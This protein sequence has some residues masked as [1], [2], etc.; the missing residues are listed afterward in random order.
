M[1]TDRRAHI[2]AEVGRGEEVAVAE[3]LK[4]EAV[5]FA[6]VL[7]DPPATTASSPASASMSCSRRRAR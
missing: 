5:A 3:R 1:S 2:L 6:A 4:A 7:D